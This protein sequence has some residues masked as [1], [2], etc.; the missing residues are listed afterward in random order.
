[1]RHHPRARALARASLG[2]AGLLLALTVAGCSSG[3]GEEVEVTPTASP[4]SSAA[5]APAEEAPAEDD[6]PG[7]GAEPSSAETSQGGVVEGLPTDVI[8]V[9]DDA[10]VLL[11][12][13][14]PDGDKVDVS[15]AARIAASPEDVLG[16]YR[17]ALTGAGFVE[18]PSAGGPG[19]TASTFT[20]GGGE[21]VVSVTVVPP[22]TPGDPNTFTIGGTVL[23]P[24]P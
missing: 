10:E 3:D 7:E 23:A 1:M 24:A 4:T 8:P 17:E 9:P 18:S 19:A 12:S 6:A 22:A 14:I 13:A 11:T 20:R 21:E 5:E 2:A 16:V 15:L